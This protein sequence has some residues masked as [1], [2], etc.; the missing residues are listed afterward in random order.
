MYEEKDIN[1]IHIYIWHLMESYLLSQQMH[2]DLTKHE[3]RTSTCA[4]MENQ[5]HDKNKNKTKR[6]HTQHKLQV[7]CPR[8]GLSSP[9]VPFIITVAKFSFPKLEQFYGRHHEL[10]DRFTYIRVSNGIG[11][12]LLYVEFVFPLLPTI[13]YCRIGFEEH[14]D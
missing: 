13:P 9:V 14:G 4:G 10:F 11:S 5:E 2:N 12:F 3:F 8:Q 7:K 6:R 1:Y